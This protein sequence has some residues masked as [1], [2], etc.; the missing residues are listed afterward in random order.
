MMSPV[1]ATQANVLIEVLK[2][3]VEIINPTGPGNPF[4]GWSSDKTRSLRHKTFHLLDLSA[5]AALHAV[6]RIQDTDEQRFA[7]YRVWSTWVSRFVELVLVHELG[8]TPFPY[9]NPHADVCLDGCPIDVKATWLPGRARSRE[10]A[11]KYLVNN[12]WGQRHEHQ[13]LLYLTYGS[14]AEAMDLGLIASKVTAWRPEFLD[15][16]TNQVDAIQLGAGA[17]QGPAA[18][19]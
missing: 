2:A 15:V 11:A 5:Q 7:A 19:E 6:M 3:L 12:A 17:N 13:W 18:A 10:D 4:K 8:A 16:G 14:W 9:T 1:L